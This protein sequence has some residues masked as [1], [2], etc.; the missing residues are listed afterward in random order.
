MADLMWVANT[1]HGP[2]GHWF[3]RVTEDDGDHDHLETA[4][5]AVSYLV[6]HR[7]AVPSTPPHPADLA[8][9]AAIR[10]MVR[11]L[12]VPGD[13]WTPD[14]LG[15][16]ARTRFELDHERHLRATGIGWEA[17]VG[18]LMLPLVELVELRD[19]LS[20]CGNPFCRL[21]F[22]DGSKSRTR[23]WCDDAGCGNRD[24]VKRHRGRVRTRPSLDMRIVGSRIALPDREELRQ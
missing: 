3:A 4:A 13:A 8:D 18:N 22:L 19:R 14:A 21:V 7:V 20:I 11:G 12:L 1:R 9:L 6:D 23:R 16:L 10:E 2:G 5:N 24:R 15:V 17:F